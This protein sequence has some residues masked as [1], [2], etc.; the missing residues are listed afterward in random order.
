MGCL[1]I[2]SYA[3]GKS[4]GVNIW[5]ARQDVYAEA[6]LLLATHTLVPRLKKWVQTPFIHS[7]FQQLHFN[8]E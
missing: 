2:A 6:A 4:A 1:S 7:P 8:P 3:S 5:T